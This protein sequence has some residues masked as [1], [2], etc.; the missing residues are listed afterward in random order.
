MDEDSKT[1][2]NQPERPSSENLKVEENSRA[3]G[4]PAA[5][6]GSA[7]QHPSTETW[8]HPESSAEAS[9]D[10]PPSQ[11]SDADGKPKTS[12]KA[13]AG[14]EAGTKNKKANKGRSKPPQKR[15]NAKSADEGA[16]KEQGGTED[17]GSASS[18]N[19]DGP[20]QVYLQGCKVDPAPLP[21]VRT[22]PPQLAPLFP[23]LLS[24]AAVL[25]TTAA[26][27]GHGLYFDRTE[28][29][30]NGSPALRVAVVGKDRYLPQSLMPAME[31]AYA[32]ER[33]DIERWAAEKEK[34]AVMVGIDAARQ[35]TYQQLVSSAV[36]LGIA[37]MAGAPVPVKDAMAALPR[38]QFV[39]RDPVQGHVK[40]ALDVARGGLL[41]I[42]GRRLP[43]VSGFGINY[44][45]ITA[46]IVN[47]S[48]AGCPLA[49]SDSRL[50]G[51]VDLRCIVVS[52]IGTITDID[53]LSL[54]KAE[55]AM[56]TGTVFVPTDGRAADSPTVDAAAVLTQSL[57]RVRKL[58][59]SAQKLGVPL[60]LSRAARKAEEQAKAKFSRSATEVLPP[61]K[62]YYGVAADLVRRIAYVLHLLDHAA[63]Q[64]DRLPAEVDRGVILRA[65]ALVERAIMP[66]ARNTLAPS[67]VA[68]EVRDAR[69]ILSFIQ[70]YTSQQH[71]KLA[72]RD[73]V[74]IF[75]RTL[76]VSAIDRAI[77][78]LVD[79]GLLTQSDSDAGGGQA[80]Q[81]NDA[82]FLASLP[83]LVSDPR[84][85]RQ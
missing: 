66:A 54:H 24:V 34:A 17:A 18:G 57:A 15:A 60:K 63:A 11:A 81:V 32:L 37:E 56:L 45:D 28:S 35:R 1:P 59:D 61:L 16:A 49:L 23:D 13:K 67:S 33:L 69:R 77:R 62:H 71:P 47:S 21:P 31:A 64:A 30:G 52:V 6:V 72:R 2:D 40:R 20:M 5:D 26:A 76:T 10:A 46:D 65:V 19:A 42:D 83:D 78:R 29:D 25:A 80:F 14:A 75:Q 73:V 38:P 8:E 82:V 39:L 12:N 3:P 7:A 74:R 43:T 41:L 36:L 79:D 50:A 22:L 44:D 68:P 53:A 84:R 9:P 48:A 55:V 27:A 4:M 51:A 70:Q 85:P 58:V